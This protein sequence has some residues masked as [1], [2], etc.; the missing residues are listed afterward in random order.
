MD[1]W[2]L[3]TWSAGI[4]FSGQNH[5]Y[6]ISNGISYVLRMSSEGSHGV[7]Y[8]ISVRLAD[9]NVVIS[10]QPGVM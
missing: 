9:S 2:Q 8:V 5:S 7:S 1:Q 4:R 6:I 3:M 10:S